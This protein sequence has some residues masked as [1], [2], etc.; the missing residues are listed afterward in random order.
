MPFP[1][2]LLSKTK[3]S[4]GDWEVILNDEHAPNTTALE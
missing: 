4:R 3:D 1:S 2:D